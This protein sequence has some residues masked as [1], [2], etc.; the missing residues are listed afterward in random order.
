MPPYL[1]PVSA[2]RALNVED[3]RIRSVLNIQAQGAVRSPSPVE[4]GRKP[5]DLSMAPFSES[6]RLHQIRGGSQLPS[7]S[8]AVPP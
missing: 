5:S 4:F 3:L 8:S 7:D 6:W 1:Q 2:L